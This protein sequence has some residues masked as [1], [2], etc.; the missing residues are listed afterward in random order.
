MQE[1][2]VEVH[3]MTQTESD[4]ETDGEILTELDL[5]VYVWEM[6]NM[7]GRKNEQRR[8]GGLFVCSISRS[9]RRCNTS[10][11]SLVAT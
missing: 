9:V 1:G 8:V 4:A 2:F 10:S 7:G 11:I 3:M 5:S 6:E